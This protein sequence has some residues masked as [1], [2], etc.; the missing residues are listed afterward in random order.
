[1]KVKPPFL[2]FYAVRALR[3]I[4]IRTFTKAAPKG[5]VTTAPIYDFAQDLKQGG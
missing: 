5:V 4:K 1:V 3:L 2:V